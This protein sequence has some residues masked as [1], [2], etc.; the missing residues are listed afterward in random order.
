MNWSTEFVE[1]NKSIHDRTTFNCGVNEL[2]TFIKTQASKHMLAGISKT[3]VLPASVPLTNGMLPIAA[4]YTITVSSIKK[5]V[6]PDTFSRKLPHYP[7]PVFLLA[8][9]A[10]QSEYQ[11]MGLGKI[12]L[13]NALKYFSEIYSHM[14]AYAVIVDC[15]NEAAETFYGK[16]GFEKLCMT[17]GRMRMFLPM[18]VI[19]QLF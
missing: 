16:F 1:L 7:V 3:M 11:K 17:N 8:Q 19:K 4:F 2:N 10:I 13:I 9:L 18:N 12:T 5:E 6:L 15:I 14:H